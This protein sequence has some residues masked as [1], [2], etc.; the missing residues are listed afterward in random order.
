M[1]HH[2][3]K[4]NISGGVVVKH[5]LALWNICTKSVLIRERGTERYLISSSVQYQ[6]KGTISFDV[7]A[8][9]LKSPKLSTSTDTL[10]YVLR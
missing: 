1:S 7:V 6:S 10:H 4:A 3:A 8:L 5:K 9:R 2:S